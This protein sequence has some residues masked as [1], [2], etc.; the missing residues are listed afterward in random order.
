M[1]D[2]HLVLLDSPDWQRFL[3]HDVLP[4]VLDHADVGGDVLE[5]GPG[6]GLMTDLLRGRVGHLVALEVDPE[7][8]GALARRLADTDVE[9]VC[10]D[11]TE[12]VLDA[13]RFTAA[14]CFTMLHHVPSPEG[15]DR[16]FAEMHRV[17]QPGGRLVGIDSLDSPA[18]RELHVD[19]VFVPVDPASLPARLRAAGFDDVQ[20]EEWVA[21]TRPGRK[22]RFVAT[23][24]RT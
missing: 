23:K 21:E 9:V 18:L 17:L 5:V 20:V 12:P 8:A 16:L 14:T 7:L 6:P 15:Q 22:V 24:S 13:D 2:A 10:G 11:A 3:D 1:N 4:W 19:D